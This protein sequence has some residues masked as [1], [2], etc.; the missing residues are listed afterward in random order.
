MGDNSIIQ[1]FRVELQAISGSSVA[2]QEAVEAFYNLAGF[3]ETL[4]E[5]DNSLKSKGNSNENIRSANILH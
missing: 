2:E 4:I 3:M 5:I 1:D